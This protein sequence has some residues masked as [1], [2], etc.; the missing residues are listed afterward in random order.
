[1]ALTPLQLWRSPLDFFQ[2]LNSDRGD[3]ATWHLPGKRIHLVSSPALVEEILVRRHPD[4]DKGAGLKRAKLLLGS[5]LL[6]S[7][8]AHHQRQRQRIHPAFHRAQVDTLVPAG[9]SFAESVTARWQPDGTTDMAE[10]M[11]RL[12]QRVVAK[13]LLD[14]DIEDGQARQIGASLNS[15]VDRFPWLF[16][17]GSKLLSRLGIPPYSRIT[18]DFDRID[19][20]VGELMREARESTEGSN[21]LVASLVNDSYEDSQ[22]SIR[23]EVLT[24]F[25]AGHDTTG[26]L[27]GWTWYLL[28]QHP[29]FE[30]RWH[31]EIDALTAAPQSLAALED[32]PF[33]KAI[34]WESLRLF[35]P[36]PLIGRTARRDMHIGEKQV[37]RGDIV[38]VSPWIVHRSNACFDNPSTFLPDRWLGDLERTLP[39]GAFFPFGLGPRVCIGMRMAWI[40]ACVVLVTIGRHWMPR[41]IGPPQ[42]EFTPRSIT[43]RPLHGLPMKL[44]TRGC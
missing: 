31:T 4:F 3:F 6:T 20:F 7:E 14:T 8:G 29:E 34:V 38:E 33:T 28:S 15:L 10:E 36:V 1:M 27:L 43:L 35:P 26:N 44:E 9:V 5:G 11:M 40:T 2:Q 24:A 25:L 19:H 30:A 17:P 37:R 39:R 22:E 32:L 18:R 12:S 13:A 41:Y 16:L 42:I 21:G 23:D